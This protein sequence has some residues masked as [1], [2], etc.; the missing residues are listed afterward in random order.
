MKVFC[1]SSFFSSSS[2]LR[3]GGQKGQA[4][5]E[6]VLI[7]T[8]SVVVIGGLLLKLNKGFQKWGRSIVGGD[9]FVSCLLQTGQLPHK[10]G[11]HCSIDNMDINVSS[12]SS[13]G[14]SLGSGSETGGGASGDSADNASSGA[15]GESGAAGGQGENLQAEQDTSGSA[16]GSGKGKKRGK[17]GSSAGRGGDPANGSVMALNSGDEGMEE[18]GSAEG[19]RTGAVSKKGRKKKRIGFKDG[20]SAYEGQPGYAGQRHRAISSYGYMDIEEK[21]KKR[22]PV[23]VSTGGGVKKKNRLGG[24]K[25]TR[26]IVQKNIT[27]K[28]EDVKVSKWSFGNIFRVVLIICIIVAMVL[29]IASQTASVRKSMK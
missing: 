28:T 15:K 5:V 13:A 17:T 6:Y 24:D 29:L 19:T 7:L 23:T 9:G 27:T 20:L 14:G 8:V 12:G 16:E 11:D 10:V 18:D 26:M 2:S 1:S 25:K 3:A 4:V 21:R 22:I